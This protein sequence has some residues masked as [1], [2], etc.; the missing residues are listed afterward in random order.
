MTVRE[1]LSIIGVNLAVITT[2]FSVAAWLL[3]PRY[4]S[5]VIE[6]LRAKKTEFEVSVFEALKAKQADYKQWNDALYS[7]WRR[8]QMDISKEAASLHQKVDSMARDFSSYASEFREHKDRIEASLS[9]LSTLPF[10]LDNLSGVV[11]RTTEIQQE[12]MDK[13]HETRLDVEVVKERVRVSHPH[14][15]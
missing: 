10:A 3:R 11:K 14:S 8:E 1:L 12:M 4:Q 13:L 6:S 2:L 7:E 5:S 15:A 9:H